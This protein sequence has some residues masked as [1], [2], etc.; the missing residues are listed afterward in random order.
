MKVA[1]AAVIGVFIIFALSRSAAMLH[2]YNSPMDV[3]RQVYNNPE[4]GNQTICVGREWYRF[5]THFFLPENYR[6]AFS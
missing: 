1:V 4:P 2:N 5:W 3:Y 6:Y